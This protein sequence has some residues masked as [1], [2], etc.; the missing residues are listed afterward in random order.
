MEK[1][2]CLNI[3]KGIACIFVVFM[4]SRFPGITGDALATAGGWAVPIF[5]MIS[6]YYAWNKNKDVGIIKTKKKIKKNIEI[7]IGTMIAYIIWDWCTALFL[8]HNVNELIKKYNVKNFLK[9]FITN[10]VDFQT[11]GQ[12]WFMVALIYAYLMTYF[13]FKIEKDEWIFP[14]VVLTLFIRVVLTSFSNYHLYLNFWFDGFP[15]FF[16]GYLIRQKNEKIHCNNSR[17]LLLGVFGAII[18]SEL[19]NIWKLPIN[20]FEI[21]T[22]IAGVLLFIFALEN[23]KIVRQ[24]LFEKI[25]VKYSLWIYLTHVMAINIM[26]VVGKRLSIHENNYYLWI[27]PIIVLSISVV[28]SMIIYNVSIILKRERRTTK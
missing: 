18:F 10:D 14:V 5:F 2:Y 23:G 25:G 12:L 22:I 4:H 17:V 26:E 28:F 13:M 21:G 24:S 20:I 9:I 1:N 15:F 16:L 11:G 7:T 3:L 6:G 8:N 19:Q 27:R